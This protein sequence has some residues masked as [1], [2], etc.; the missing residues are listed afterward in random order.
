MFLVVE[1]AV[2]QA[3]ADV[4]S[5]A[6][7]IV[8]CGVRMFLAVSVLLVISAASSRSLI[9]IVPVGLLWGYKFGGYTSR[10][11]GAPQGIHRGLS[12]R[13]RPCLVWRRQ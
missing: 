7:R 8:L 3:R 2:S 9:V 4:L 6:I 5:V 11:G 1:P 13:S 12:A 10:K